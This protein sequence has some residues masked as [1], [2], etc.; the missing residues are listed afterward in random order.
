M[1][2][3]AEHIEQNL[4]KRGFCVVFENELNRWWSSE[5]T[6]PADREKQIQ[7]FPKSRGWIVSILDTDSGMRAIFKH[8]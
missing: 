7:T 3:L 8:R 1:D 5:K 6:K 4:R 2:T